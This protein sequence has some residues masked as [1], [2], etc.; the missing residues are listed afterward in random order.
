[1][2]VL[3][4]AIVIATTAALLAVQPSGAAPKR[5]ASGG[6]SFDG[7]WSVAIYPSYGACGSYRAAVR[8]AGGSVQAAG[9]DF[10]A[11]GSVNRSG[12]IS[13]RVSSGAGSASGSGRLSGSHGGGRWRTD[14]GQCGG[15]W[16]ASKRG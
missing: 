12:G 1:M 6:G 10:S 16:A 9:G 3:L 14:G 13:V 15:S 7:L 11:Y 8:I 5:H 4:R 2:K